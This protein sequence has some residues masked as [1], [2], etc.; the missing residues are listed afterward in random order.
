MIGRVVD[1]L[2][3]TIFYDVHC[4]YS[5]RVLTWLADLGPA[6]VA[7]TYRTFPLEQVNRDRTAL[8]WRIWDQPLDYEHHEGRAD[9]RALL[10]FLA[11]L[12]AERIAPDVTVDRFR[13]LVSR[14]RHGLGRNIADPTVLLEFAAE[15]GVDPVALGA[16]LK[17]EAAVTWA[18]D[19]IAADWADA[20]REYEIFGVPTL[21]LDGVPPFYL[22]LERVPRGDDALELLESIR[23]F[24]R[25]LPQVV[26]IKVPERTRAPA[27]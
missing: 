21:R 25:R 9:R 18:R 8:G 6:R 27:A 15:A 20:R 1:P 17:D 24:G 14:A 23:A 19:R 11:I 13:L 12:L 5:D 7:P 22:R 2:A 10:A 4:P 26:E 16:L 3:L